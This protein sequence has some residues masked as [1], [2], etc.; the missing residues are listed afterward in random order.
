MTY[1]EELGLESSASPEEIRR[2][3]RKLAQLLHPDR[4]QDQT[5]RRICERQ[6][7]RLNGIAEV[8]DDPRRRRSYDLLLER[9]NGSRAAPPARLERARKLISNLG[10][11]AWVWIAAAALGVLL[12]ALLFR[13]N[14]VSAVETPDRTARA[15]ELP[16]P[17]ARD[18]PAAAHARAVP[19]KPLAPPTTGRTG[20]RSLSPLPPE[21]PDPSPPTTATPLPTLSQAALPQ[22]APAVPT[23]P[24]T[25]PPSRDEPP[26]PPPQPQSNQ[27]QSNQSQPNQPPSNQSPSNQP[28]SNRPPSN[29]PQSYFAG[30]WFFSHDV[31]RR[32]RALYPPEMIEL[33]ITEDGAVLRGSYR[34]RYRVPDRPISPDV[35][36]EFEGPAGKGQ[37]VELGW[38]GSGGAEGRVRLTALTR[39]SMEVNWWA[40]RL[41][42]LGLVSG[43]A[44]LIRGA[45]Q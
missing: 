17:E 30:R 16:K 10:L 31:S 41:G 27:P 24:L 4:H 22:L 2:A 5:L 19:N 35:S 14:A 11:E 42:S 13:W 7:A 20:P 21:V 6:L 45:D 33:A 1:Y 38:T 32:D 26:P 9:Q 15:R 44:V 34:G 18:L 29:R 23:A 37:T 40:T 12:M 25:P 3:Y 43:T 28:Q 36:F 8:L 39:V